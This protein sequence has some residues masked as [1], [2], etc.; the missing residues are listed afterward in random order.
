MSHSDEL[1]NPLAEALQLLESDLHLPRGFLASLYAEESDW[2]FVIK[3]HALVEAALTHLIVTAIGDNRLGQLVGR[4]ET[5]NDVTGKL[6][7]IKKMELLPDRYRRF[8]RSFSELRN[9]LVHDVSNS[10]FAF[11]S[12]VETLSKERR[13]T[14]KEAF[15]FK[16]RPRPEAPQDDWEE[17]VLKDPKFAILM[18]TFKL[19]AE[20]YQK[21][22]TYLIDDEDVDDELDSSE[23]E[24]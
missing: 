12:H 13:K 9:S 3:T 1:P 8:V 15:S 10:N 16:T 17:Q 5:S 19:L 21:K 18:N 2:A 7:F 23:G 22:Q 14:F 11:E 24:G 20:A 4:L 6:A